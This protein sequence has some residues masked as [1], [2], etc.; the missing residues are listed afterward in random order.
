VLKSSLTP[1][2]SPP[3]PGGTGGTGTITLN[4]PAGSLSGF[5]QIFP[6][7][8]AG[9]GNYAA[10]D[11]Q[12]FTATIDGLSFDFTSIGGNNGQLD[13][14]QFDNG[15]ITSINTAGS[16]G[17]NSTSKELLQIGGG[18][19]SNGDVTVQSTNGGTIDF[20]DSYAITG[21]MVAAVPE[22]CTWA[23]MILGFVGVGFMAYRRK[24]NGPALRL[25]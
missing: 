15:N 16:G 8:T 20:S 9:S 11:F 21:P 4:L 14:I 23:M 3:P 1:L 12:S 2:H 24:Q 22:P 5:S 7:S 13:G 19:N 17:L 25:A 6:G 10:S 18:P